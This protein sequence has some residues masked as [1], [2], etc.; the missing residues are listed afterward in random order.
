V[1][2]DRAAVVG[3]AGLR[4]RSRARTLSTLASERSIDMG[5]EAAVEFANEAFYL[6]FTTRD[7]KGMGEIWAEE[8]EIV[9]IHPGW[10]PIHG[11]EDV[12]QSWAGILGSRA[13]P[14]VSCKWPRVHFLG[15]DAAFVTCYE[16]LEEGILAA[17]NVFVREKGAWRLVHHQASPMAN[18]P[19]LEDEGQPT[20][21]L[22]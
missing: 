21:R 11:R 22:Q 2:A 13:A 12:M 8:H 5:L 15:E 6:A 7:L 16:V 20:T 4:D 14:A 10:Q 18:P 17:T 19:R 3:R 9:C 1:A